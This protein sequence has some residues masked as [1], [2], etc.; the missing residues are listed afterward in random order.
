MHPAPPPRLNIQVQPG[1]KETC[2]W[3]DW[4][5]PRDICLDI[6][7]W[8]RRLK[9]CN[10]RLQDLNC[11]KEWE[12][13]ETEKASARQFKCLNVLESNFEGKL[14]DFCSNA[15]MRRQTIKYSGNSGC[16][17]D[18]ATSVCPSSSAALYWLSGHCAALDQR[19]WGRACLHN[20]RWNCQYQLHFT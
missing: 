19:G 17:Q 6:R 18:S 4:G 14:P 7:Q 3:R 12:G 1:T 16:K 2:A 20:Y 11:V 15:N 8:G 13:C 9:P 5:N 10:C